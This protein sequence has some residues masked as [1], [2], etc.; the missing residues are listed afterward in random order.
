MEEGQH[1]NRAGS[2][3]AINIM[4]FLN[5][6]HPEDLQNRWLLNLAHMTLGTYPDG[7]NASELIKIPDEVDFSRF[8]EIAMST[9][10]AQHGLSGGV[11]VDDFN[12]D[13]FLD[14]FATSYG[15]EDMVIVMS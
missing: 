3:G 13:G 2:E 4:S 11:C 9:G 5:K 14:I 6:K 15:M 12:N 7:L 1:Q 8:D 10:V